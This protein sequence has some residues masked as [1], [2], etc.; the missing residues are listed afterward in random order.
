MMKNSWIQRFTPRRSKSMW[1]KRN[2][3][4]VQKLIDEGRMRA[5]GLKVIDEAKADGR[6]D[7][8]YPSPK[9]MVLPAEYLKRIKTH[10][11]AYEV[12]QT[13]NKSKL[14]SIAMQ[15]HTA[16]KEETRLKRLDSIIDLLQKGEF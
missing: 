9:D 12:Y 1:S 6:W 13:L 14:Y 4:I 7:A 11:K 2:T 3:L 5:A 16:K 10:K 8:A 15:V